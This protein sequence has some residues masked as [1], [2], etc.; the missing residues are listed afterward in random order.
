M[1]QF[2]QIDKSQCTLLYSNF[3]CPW[4]GKEDIYL[5]PLGMLHLNAD[6]GRIASGVSGHEK[7]PDIKHFAD[8][9]RE[10]WNE[11]LIKFIQ[12]SSSKE[13]NDRTKKSLFQDGQL[14]VGAILSDG[15]VVAGNRRCSILMSL[16]NE[17]GNHERFGYFKCAI[18]DVPNT[19]EGRKQLKRLE[20]KTQ[21]GEDTPVAY[22][23]IERLVDIYN[24]VIA[25]GHPYSASEYQNFLG[26]KRSQMDNLV[27]RAKILV[28][29]LEYLGKPGNYEVARIEK[30]DGPINELA[31]LCKKVNERD[32]NRIKV[33][34]YRTLAGGK[35]GDRTR[36]IRAQIKVY[37]EN[38]EKIE[39]DLLEQ[40]DELLSGD[41]ENL[42]LERSQTAPVSQSR[43]DMFVEAAMGI[44]K[45]AARTKPIAYV[46]HALDELNKL[47]RTAV[48]IMKEGEKASFFKKLD[49]LIQRAQK[50]TKDKFE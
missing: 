25:P 1:S 40:E 44:Q 37:F 15:T 9:S 26:L 39:N 8:M 42:G 28:D 50:F 2:P 22:G 20:T 10:E 19:E 23:P 7:N 3:D 34:F 48:S 36:I 30:L 5:V 47:D 17:T 33:S 11:T 31:L 41:A 14:K 4:G 46:E 38:P 49:I 13:D 27:L 35:K 21:Y 45:E 12:E 16:L 29:Y 18:F 32:W 43:E 24:N 6:N